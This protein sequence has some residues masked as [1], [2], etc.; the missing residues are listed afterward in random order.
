MRHA[1]ERIAGSS[2]RSVG[3]ATAGESAGERQRILSSRNVPKVEKLD[4]TGCTLEV[5][6]PLLSFYGIHLA[7]TLCWSC[8]L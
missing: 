7:Q 2:L 5:V 1:L 4:L 8:M 6:Q 3:L